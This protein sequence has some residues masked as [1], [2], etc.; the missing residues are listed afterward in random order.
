MPAAKIERH[1]SLARLPHAG[2]VRFTRAEFR[3]GLPLDEMAY[4]THQL[5][6]S[7]SRNGVRCGHTSIHRGVGD[8]AGDA[9]LDLGKLL[10]PLDFIEPAGA[11]TFRLNKDQ[12]VRNLIV[13]IGV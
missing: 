12:C 2:Y 5:A 13:R 9:R 4:A 11:I 1:A 3:V 10:D 7:Q 8:N 6:V